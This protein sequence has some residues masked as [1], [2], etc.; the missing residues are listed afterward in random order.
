MALLSP[1]QF[2]RAHTHSSTAAAAAPR[3]RRPSSSSSSASASSFVFAASLP[4]CDL[5]SE[6]SPTLGLPVPLKLKNTLSIF[7]F[8]AASVAAAAGSGFLFRLSSI[9]PPAN[10]SGGG[11]GGDG[12]GWGWGWG[13]GGDG[14]GF[15]FNVFSPLPASANENEQAASAGSVEW[16]SHGLPANIVVQL[17]KLSGLKRYKISEILLFD[18]RRRGTAAGTEDSFFEMV[19]LR[20]GGVYTKAQLQTELE[21]LASCGMFERV[22]LEGKTKPDGTLAV[23]VSFLESTWQSADS[24]R[25][26]NVGLMPQS[27]QM[28]MDPDMTD[29]EK[30]EYFRNQERDYRRRIERSRPCLLPVTV[31]REV[32]QMLREQGRVTARLLQRIR[33]RVQKWYHDE[34]YACAQVVN[35]GNLNTKEVVCEVVEGDITQLAIQFQDKL[36]NVCEGNTKFG[37][38]RR[39]LPKQVIFV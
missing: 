9:P 15:W 20:P 30:L 25:C 2:R 22:D 14:G 29:K 24:F 3:R 16:D 11:G 23:T 38:I 36:G 7:N 33:D 31:Q 6:R 21:T 4:D 19:S 39:E 5:S 10:G 26:I 1:T 17:S 13:W 18:R 12:G 8:A 28:E 34:G 32:L 27:K 37:V 35:F